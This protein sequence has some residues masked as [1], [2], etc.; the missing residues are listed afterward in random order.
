MCANM[1]FKKTRMVVVGLA[2]VTNI[3]CLQKCR[4]LFEGYLS[5]LRRC[6]TRQARQLAYPGRS[7]G[8][9]G[10]DEHWGADLHGMAVLHRLR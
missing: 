7:C 1:K 2:N 4:I 10:A 3:W 8:I 5:H 6:A 9:A